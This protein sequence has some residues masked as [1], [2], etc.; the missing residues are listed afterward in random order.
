VTKKIG[1]NEFKK[2]LEGVL[3]E[4]TAFTLDK[5]LGLPKAVKVKNFSHPEKAKITK[6]FDY[7]NKTNLEKVADND[8]SAIVLSLSDFTKGYDNDDEFSSNL[9]DMAKTDSI[10]NKLNPLRTAAFKYKDFNTMKGELDKPNA[11]SNLMK[12]FLYYFFSDKG[13]L[14]KD[15]KK[16]LFKAYVNS[17]FAKTQ[18][19]EFQLLPAEIR[20]FLGTMSSPTNVD[21]AASD[22]G[23]SGFGEFPSTVAGQSISPDDWKDISGLKVTK[24][25]MISDFVKSIGATTYDEAL[26][27]IANFSVAATAADFQT[28]MKEWMEENNKN[29]FDLVNYAYVLSMMADSA[30]K[31]ESSNAGAF[32]E[33]MLSY[34]L[35]MP[36][37][38]G[39]GQ[40]V[41]NIGKVLGQQT[42]T[43]AKF[44]V[45]RSA[46]KQ[47]TVNLKAQVKDSPAGIFYLCFFKMADGSRGAGAV[48]DA[49]DVEI[50]KITLQ[51]DKLI[52]QFVKEDL[53]LGEPYELKE[54][55]TK[56]QIINAD[57][58]RHVFASIK[59][60]PTSET[61][62]SQRFDMV[63][64]DSM[65]KATDNLLSVSKA[66]TSVTD[67]S[68]E[69]NQKTK[70]L[71]GE[72][73]AEGG[74][75]ESN[76]KQA[77][78]TE[79][80]AITD[81]LK[82][83]IQ[84]IFSGITEKSEVKESKKITADFLKKLILESF[85]K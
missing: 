11:D 24:N 45:Q 44:Y 48:Y 23:F 50:S 37:V 36:T 16:D 19:T 22:S 70:S 28:K 39:S 41:D 71:S 72:V 80:T 60:L 5:D 9:T 82:N 38:G 54:S 57:A 77:L 2:L 62:N 21:V 34:L 17:E 68:V 13:N 67:K 35:L 30:K 33:G 42:Y 56:H 63:F 78:S 6:H 27:E 32:M 40:A 25:K 4:K 8:G 31:T 66:L 81:L 59:T 49:I 43:S 20:T 7:G 69:L 47:D 14:N 51:D 73:G 83:S 79:F 76:R 58:T 85:K 55:G 1:K 52:G 3:S 10:K 26:N 29:Q 61:D 53:S 46:P 74:S 12:K 65:E 15:Q 84:T 18:D 64:I 75:L